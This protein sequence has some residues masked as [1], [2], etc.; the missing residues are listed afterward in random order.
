MAEI[1]TIKKTV[2][3]FIGCD[4]RFQLI[5]IGFPFVFVAPELRGSGGFLLRPHFR[6]S[7]NDEKRKEDH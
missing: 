5:M 2:T 7:S 3:Q 6:E 4:T 1:R